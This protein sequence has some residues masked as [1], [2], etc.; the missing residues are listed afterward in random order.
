MFA[1][2]LEHSARMSGCKLL[3]YQST[4]ETRENL[5]GE[6]EF[7][8]AGH[9]PCSI[10]RDA[11]A[12]NNHVDVWMVVERRAPGVENRENANVSAQVL[13]IGCNRGHG[14]G[15]G[16]EQDVVD[17]GLVL[18]GDVGDFARQREHHM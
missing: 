14:F 4:E 18:I 16:L 8:P 17:Y 1:E 10:E 12:R 6:E 15:R 7:G 13:G 2:E 9:P 11:A 5:N 3:Q